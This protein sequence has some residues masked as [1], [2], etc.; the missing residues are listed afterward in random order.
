MEPIVD[1]SLKV[2]HQMAQFVFKGP[3]EEHI[4]PP[5]QLLVMFTKVPW[6]VT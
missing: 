3:G 4:L 1:T 2:Q 5:I 6:S